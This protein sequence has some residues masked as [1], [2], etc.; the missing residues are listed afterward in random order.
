MGWV[1]ICKE[2]QKDNI[3]INNYVND[4]EEGKAIKDS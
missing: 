2:L 3:D 1:R 4:P